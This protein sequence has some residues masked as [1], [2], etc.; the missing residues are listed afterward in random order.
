MA[1]IPQSKDKLH[2]MQTGSSNFFL[3]VSM[4]VCIY[5]WPCDTLTNYPGCNTFLLKLLLP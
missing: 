2:I 4:V 3:S 5:V 1:S